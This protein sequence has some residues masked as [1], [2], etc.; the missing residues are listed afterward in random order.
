VSSL[1]EVRVEKEKEMQVSA[2]KAAILEKQLK[3]KRDEQYEAFRR[4]GKTDDGK[5]FI[6]FIKEMKYATVDALIDNATL[7]ERALG[8][9]FERLRAYKNILRLLEGAKQ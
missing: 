9:S 5:A 2:E 7:D 1:N 8:Y 6:A 3:A 4:I